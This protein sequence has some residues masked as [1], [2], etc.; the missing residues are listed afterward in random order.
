MVLGFG[1]VMALLGVVSVRHFV[2]LVVVAF[3]IWVVGFLID[4]WLVQW[5]DGWLFAL[6]VYWLLFRGL[7]AVLCGAMAFDGLELV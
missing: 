7:L 4:V 2:V 5:F 6:W 3:R 1:V